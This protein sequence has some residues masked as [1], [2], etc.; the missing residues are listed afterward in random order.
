MK[1]S[2][3]TQHA[4]DLTIRRLAGDPLA[5]AEAIARHYTAHAHSAMCLL[6]LIQSTRGQLTPAVREVIQLMVAQIQAGHLH[7]LGLYLDWRYE[8]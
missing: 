6:K 7:D 8:I 3:V 5:Q 4:V 1:S 2:H